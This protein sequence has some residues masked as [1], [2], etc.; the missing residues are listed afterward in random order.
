MIPLAW[1]ARG[2][3]FIFMHDNAPCLRAN[4]VSEWLNEQDIEVKAWPPQSPDLNPIEI[5]WDYIER[6]VDK[7][8]STTKEDLWKNMKSV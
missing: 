5:L 7:L 3:D 4:I 1:A 8:P 2:L 6:Q